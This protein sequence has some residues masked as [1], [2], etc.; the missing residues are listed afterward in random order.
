MLDFLGLEFD[1]QAMEL[2]LSAD[3]L[4]KLHAL[5]HSWLQRQSCTKRELESLIGSLQS[6]S[7]WQNL[8]SQ[9]I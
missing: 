1:T 7:V 5:V 3:K 6:Y 2:R 8:P 4:V 9:V